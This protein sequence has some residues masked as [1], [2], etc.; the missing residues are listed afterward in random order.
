MVS[1]VLALWAV[2][3]TVQSD[4]SPMSKA[5]WC[6]L[7]LFLPFFGFVLWLFFGPRSARVR[8]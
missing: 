6:V 7:V 5:I 2:F 8:R 1:L 4:K 3:H